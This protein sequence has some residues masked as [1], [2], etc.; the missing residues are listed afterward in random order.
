M[1]RRGFLVWDMQL[2]VLT[3]F[4]SFKMVGNQYLCIG[5]RDY[6]AAVIPFDEQAHG[7]CRRLLIGIIVKM[8]CNRYFN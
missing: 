5:Q 3:R 7:K 1:F 2:L 4:T 8:A 6:D